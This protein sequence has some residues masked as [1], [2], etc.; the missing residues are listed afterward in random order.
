MMRHNIL[1]IAS[2]AL[3]AC[4]LVEIYIFNDL[5]G[6]IIGAV[7]SFLAAIAWYAI[8]AIEDVLEQNKKRI[9]EEERKKQG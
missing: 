2:L 1:I 6:G 5:H 4:A 7:C 8:N 9:E 3:F